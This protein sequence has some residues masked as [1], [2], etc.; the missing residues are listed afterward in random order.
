MVWLIDDKYETNM[1]I[2]DEVNDVVDDVYVYVESG[3]G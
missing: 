3:P 2:S 1:M